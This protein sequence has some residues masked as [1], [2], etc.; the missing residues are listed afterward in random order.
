MRLGAYNCLLK[1]GSLAE[2]AYGTSVISERHRHRW[3]F[4]NTY[5]DQMEAK[6]LVISGVLENEN[7]C[8]IAE[9]KDQPWMVG[10]Q[11]HPEFKS[12]PTKAHPLFKNFIAA[13]ILYHESK[14]L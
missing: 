1:S 12:K 13:A 6:G 10:V 5:K 4:N 14:G 7:L 11:F 8:E 3:E 2:K 9:I